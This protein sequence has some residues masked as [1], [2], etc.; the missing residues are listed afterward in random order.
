MNDAE[1]TKE[2]CKVFYDY[3]IPDNFNGKIPLTEDELAVTEWMYEKLCSLYEE[4]GDILQ[5]VTAFDIADGLDI[6]HYK[7]LEVIKTLLQKKIIFT[8]DGFNLTDYTRELY[9]MP[10]IN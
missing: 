5:G 6:N 10:L 7:V 1:G 4:T 9:N 3:E 2:P 8:S